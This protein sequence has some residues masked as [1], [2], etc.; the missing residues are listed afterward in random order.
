MWTR[1]TIIQLLNAHKKRATYSAVAGCCGSTAQVVMFGL[2][3]CPECSWVVAQ[4]TGRPSSYS[5]DQI[6]PECR[7]QIAEDLWNF[8]SDATR[9]EEWLRGLA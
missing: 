7:R 9:L 6:H 4:R 2:D 1:E 5:E 3:R 8:E